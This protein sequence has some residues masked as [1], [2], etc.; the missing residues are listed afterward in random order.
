MERTKDIKGIK[1]CRLLVVDLNKDKKN[2]RAARWNCVCDCGNMVVVYGYALRN[3]SIKSCGCLRKENH[4]AAIT[5][6]GGTSFSNGKKRTYSIW[7]N[8][9]QRCLNPKNVNYHRYGGRG[10]KICDRWGQYINFISDMGEAP[11]CKTLDRIDN[12]GDY[13]K[14]NCRWTSKKVQSNNRCDNRSI[15]W[16]GN[17][18]TYAEL[19]REWGV[20][21]YFIRDYVD[22]RGMTVDELYKKYLKLAS[23]NADELIDQYRKG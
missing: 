18:Y 3:G 20:S 2:S 21:W 19:A 11:P 9:R 17:T 23:T 12:N 10:I 6:H 5:K 8:M 4:L 15:S 1:Y 13:C 14:E 22:R 16:D 7:S